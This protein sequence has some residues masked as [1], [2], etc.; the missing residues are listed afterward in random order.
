MIPAIQRCQVDV[1]AYIKFA[2]VTY[3]FK[4][5]EK[6]DGSLDYDHQ[7]VECTPDDYAT[8]YIVSQGVYSYPM[9]YGWKRMYEKIKDLQ[10][11]DPSSIVVGT[12]SEGEI[13]SYGMLFQ[14]D[15]DKNV[16]KCSAFYTWKIKKLTNSGIEYYNARF[17]WGVD[18]SLNPTTAPKWTGD[19]CI[20]TLKQTREGAN[21]TI[22]II[23]TSNYL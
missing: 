18:E 12:D 9:Q 1:K 5:F 8:E 13:H 14:A 6:A 23:E 7:T 11:T 21:G 17:L 16:P 15:N 19:N 4:M 20:P 3:N 10:D 2:S 22:Q